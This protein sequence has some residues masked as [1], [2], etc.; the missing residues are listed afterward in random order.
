MVSSTKWVSQAHIVPLFDLYRHTKVTDFNLHIRIYEN[1]LEREIPMN[2]ILWL[3]VF[4]SVN[5][6]RHEISDLHVWKTL[7]ARLATTRLGGKLPSLVDEIL[8]RKLVAQLQQDIDVGTI[9]EKV[10]KLNDVFVPQRLMKLEFILYF[11]LGSVIYQ[12]CLL[13]HFEGKFLNFWIMVVCEG[14]V[15]LKTLTISTFPKILL[16]KIEF[17]SNL[18]GRIKFF[19]FDALEGCPRKELLLIIVQ[20]LFFHNPVV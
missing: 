11:T 12:F 4:D 5:N 18:N 17:L 20:N 6:L 10:L 8:E 3:Q 19:E 14:R 7:M 9:F 15:D 16:L 2:D 13:N 1:I